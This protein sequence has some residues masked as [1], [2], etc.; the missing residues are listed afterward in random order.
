M[1]VLV[2]TA[3]QFVITAVLPVENAAGFASLL[4]EH[5]LLGHQVQAGRTEKPEPGIFWRACELAG[6]KPDE[7]RRRLVWQATD[8]F[9]P[10]NTQAALSPLATPVLSNEL[11]WPALLY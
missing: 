4:T 6:C 7:V 2:C 10:Q 9:K 1:H 11:S 8:A 3:R 5:V